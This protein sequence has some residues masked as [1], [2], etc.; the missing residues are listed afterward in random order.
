M[1]LVF[2]ARTPCLL[3]N[4]YYS[5]LNQLQCLEK[6]LGNTP[7]LKEKY[8]QTLSTDLIKNYIK[9]VEMTEPEP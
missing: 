5:A 3:E 6:R 9:S 4:N 2:P 1:K 8:D 7:M